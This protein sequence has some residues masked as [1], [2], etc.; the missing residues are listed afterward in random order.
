MAKYA[1]YSDFA[2]LY[3]DLLGEDEFNRLV[4]PVEAFVDSVTHDRART[5]T[6]YKA[7][8]VKCAV[9]AAVREA[10]AQNAAKSSGG[11]RLQSVSNDGYTETYD[12]RDAMSDEDAISR[13]IRQWLSGTGLVSA[14]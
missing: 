13:T 2:E 1:P 14:L 8:R 7:E 11:A 3:P 9:C 5:A 6:G 4:P 10:A 12:R